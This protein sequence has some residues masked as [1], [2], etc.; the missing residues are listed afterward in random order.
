MKGTLPKFQGGNEMSSLPIAI[1]VY[2]VRDDA[3]ADLYATL[4]KI[5]EMGYDG[6]EFAGLYGNS[7]ATI[8][9]WSS[10]TPSSRRK[11][12]MV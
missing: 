5:K 3:S 2:S 7:P 6:V 4:K 8:K 1:Q 12:A 9:A 11:Q 10:L